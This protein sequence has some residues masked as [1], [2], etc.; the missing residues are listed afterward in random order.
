MRP[1]RL[2]LRLRGAV[3]AYAG[4]RTATRATDCI[5]V[6]SPRN[7]FD[8]SLVTPSPVWREL[9]A[10]QQARYRVERITT[11]GRTV[12]DRVAML[13]CA[14]ADTLAATPAGPAPG[15]P[16]AARPRGCS[17]CVT[18]VPGSWATSSARAPASTDGPVIVERGAR[19]RRAAVR[20]TGPPRLGRRAAKKDVA[21]EPLVD[22][23]LSGRPSGI[24]PE[25]CR[26]AP[27]TTARSIGFRG[28]SDNPIAWLEPTQQCN[29]ACDGCYRMNVKTTSPS[30]R[31]RTTR[32]L[33]QAPEL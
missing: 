30:S 4:E 12:R 18:D 31:S 1:V 14:L 13:L 6:C 27:S 17:A 7:V 20:A 32:R 26:T 9:L 24:I 5:V 8:T 29:L 2:C 22:L 19:A 21:R 3:R 25:R 23:R 11:R 16:P 33:L 28:A 15:R 10:M